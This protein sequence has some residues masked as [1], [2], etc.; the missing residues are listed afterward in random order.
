[1]GPIPIRKGNQK[2]LERVNTE[3]AHRLILSEKREKTPIQ[4]SS[5]SF[6]K[7]S[8]VSTPS[9]IPTLSRSENTEKEI[10]ID[11]PRGK[12]LKKPSTDGYLSDDTHFT[13]AKRDYSTFR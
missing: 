11:S 10:S 12:K 4:R 7:L 6:Q 9:I 8:N 1:M 13:R 3:K 2:G 5:K